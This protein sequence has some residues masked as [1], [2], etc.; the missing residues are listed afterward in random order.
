MDI[1][2]DNVITLGTKDDEIKRKVMMV[3]DIAMNSAMKVMGDDKAH[4]AAIGIGLMQG[5]KYK[6]SLA[7]G[8]KGAVVTYA[9]FVISDAIKSVVSDDTINK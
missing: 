1:K 7:N 3:K 4:M 5:L 8:L 6:G 2:D 9:A